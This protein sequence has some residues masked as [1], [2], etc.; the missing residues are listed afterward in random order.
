MSTSATALIVALTL[1]LAACDTRSTRRSS[2]PPAPPAPTAPTATPAPA[3][4]RDGDLWTLTTTLRTVTG[5]DACGLT[6][7]PGE[8]VRWDMT[9]T[10]L[11]GGAVNIIVADERDPADHYHYTGVI[12][13]DTL[14]MADDGH[15]AAMLCNGTR[16]DMVTESRVHGTFVGDGHTLLAEERVTARLSSGQTLT[17]L[18]E[19]RA[20]WPRTGG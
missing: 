10:L 5:G 17:W 16:V 1:W 20:S 14:T 18:Y 3:P 6:S 13:R 12:D 15:P 9:L 7:T 19:W 11:G 4:R 8:T 2:F